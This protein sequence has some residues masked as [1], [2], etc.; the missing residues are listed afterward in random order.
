[1]SPV[2]WNGQGRATLLLPPSSLLVVGR[3]HDPGVMR[4]GELTLPLTSCST[5]ESGLAPYLGSTVELTLVAGTWMSQPQVQEPGGD[6]LTP[7]LL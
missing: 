7:C 3:R 2:Q 6:G 4:A 5:Q 1:M